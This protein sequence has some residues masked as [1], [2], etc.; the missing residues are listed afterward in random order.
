MKTRLKQLGAPVY[1][2]K[3]FLWKRL[4]E[5][6]HRASA[7][8]AYQHELTRA[9]EERREAQGEHP[10]RMLV[11]PTPPTELEMQMHSM[12][13]IP[14]KPWCPLCIRGKAT[15]APHRAVLPSEREKEIPAIAIDFMYLKSDGGGTEDSSAAWSTTLVAI[16]KSISYPLAIAVDGKGAKNGPYMAR[17]V[18]MLMKQLCHKKVGLRHDGEPAMVEL[19]SRIQTARKQHGLDIVLQ[20]VPE[21][22]HQS[23]GSVEK[24]ND[25]VQKQ[26]RTLRFD[27]E[28][29]AGLTMLPTSPVWT[30]MVRH[31][32]W[33]LARY[34]VKANGRTARQDGFATDYR[35]EICPFGEVVMAKRNVSDSGA[36]QGGGRLMKADTAWDKAVWLGRSDGTDEHL[37]GDET[38]VYKTR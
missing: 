36:I 24:A 1:G 28:E 34:A 16:D 4:Q 10:A 15:M 38:G 9:A 32:A 17:A 8:L 19:A 37:V 35:G 18:I 29:R 13:H 30:W 7:E 25:L 26:V 2:D 5:Y 12:T 23:N 6:E 14:A 3:D 11:A 33:T 22:S 21:Y 20:K 27:L 31:S